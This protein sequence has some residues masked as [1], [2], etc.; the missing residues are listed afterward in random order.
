MSEI[1]EDLRSC[2]VFR[3]SPC[4][5]SHAE[6]ESTPSNAQMTVKARRL[7]YN[8]AATAELYRRADML[9]LGS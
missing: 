6:D 7:Q 8:V 4:D 5:E 2:C 9:G 1:L 3:V